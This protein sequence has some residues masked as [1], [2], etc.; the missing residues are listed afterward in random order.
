MLEQRF[1]DLIAKLSVV[2]GGAIQAAPL[3]SDTA[4]TK[5]ED[6]ILSD[7]FTRPAD[8]DS[9]EDPAWW[10]ARWDRCP[11]GSREA[12]CGDLEDFL[13]EY[14]VSPSLKYSAYQGTRE[15]ELKI[16]THGGTLREV[17]RRF[18]VSH[19]TVLRYRKKYGLT[20]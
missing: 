11:E 1:R 13:A 20:K 9:R 16:A 10:I 19:P 15:Y 2:S 6:R 18:G 7:P 8:V 14:K 3:S 5:P 17:A 12:L 4:K